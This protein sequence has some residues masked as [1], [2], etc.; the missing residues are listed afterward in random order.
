MNNKNFC[1]KSLAIALIGV[2]PVHA[3]AA[4]YPVTATEFTAGT[5]AVASDVNTNFSKLVTAVNDLNTR[6]QTLESKHDTSLCDTST[7]V[8]AQ[9]KLITSAFAA[10][11]FGSGSSLET[12]GELGKY[13]LC[14][15]SDNTFE[16]AM[17]FESDVAGTANITP[18][19]SISAAMTTD[20]RTYP[21]S[22]GSAPTSSIIEKITGTY[23]VKE[24]CRVDLYLKQSIDYDTSGTQTGS[25]GNGT[26]TF[27]TVKMHAIPSLEMMVGISTESDEGVT[28]SEYFADF[29]L[30][31][32]R[33]VTENTGLLCDK[34]S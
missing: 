32:K 7:A 13:D 6:L 8:N 21:T 14:I 19:P 2:P 30:A 4:S 34:G 18:T 24:S 28:E 12:K 5:P 3:G 29:L 31:V 17:H 10:A 33:A 26:D 23:Q 15:R 22:Y 9:Y 27:K 25:Y 20:K 11:T 16:L 1:L